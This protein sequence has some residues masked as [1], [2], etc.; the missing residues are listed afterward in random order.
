MI[1]I[2]SGKRDSA[3]AAVQTDRVFTP[4]N[5]TYSTQCKA[6][7]VPHVFQKAQLYNVGIWDQGSS[8]YQS[9]TITVAAERSVR[10]Q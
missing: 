3:Y 10:R 8:D 2:K 6:N 1:M 5:N 9:I 7:S 4:R